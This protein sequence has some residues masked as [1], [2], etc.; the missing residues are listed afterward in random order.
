MPRTLKQKTVDGETYRLYR[1]SSNR[2]GERYEYYVTE[3][4]VGKSNRAT[5]IVFSRQAADRLYDD[6][7][8]QVKRATESTSGGMGM[9]MGMNSGGMDPDPLADV[10]DVT[11][12]P[13]P[14]S[15]LDSGVDSESDVLDKFDNL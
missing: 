3:G 5:K 1:Q 2:D 13:D 10:D 8:R 14:L 9:G 15:D 6:T 7:I 12:D 4:G 11:V